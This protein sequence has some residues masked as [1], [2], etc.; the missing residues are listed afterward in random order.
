MRLYA[1]VHTTI[2]FLRFQHF[3]VLVF[4]NVIVSLADSFA[5]EFVFVCAPTIIGLAIEAYESVA[6]TF[7][8]EK[9]WGALIKSC[10]R[11]CLHEAA[12]Y[13]QVFGTLHEVR[14]SPDLPG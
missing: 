13:V 6:M 1:S 8:F 2:A 11:E 10:V 4:R 3:Q 9:P 12:S 14:V 5:G 7:D